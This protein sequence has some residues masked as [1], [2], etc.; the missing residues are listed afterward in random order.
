M[1]AAQLQKYDALTAKLIKLGGEH[2]EL[3][4]KLKSRTI[5]SREAVRLRAVI[6]AFNETYKA[7]K[8][9]EDENPIRAANL[10][11]R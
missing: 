5:T 3:V 11:K 2:R 8:A 7:R 10:L 4:A 6:T 1:T 9:L